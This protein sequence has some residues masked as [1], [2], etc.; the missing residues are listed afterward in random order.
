VGWLSLRLWLGICALGLASTLEVAAQ[1]LEAR[2]WTH[3]PVGTNIAGVGYG[4]TTGDLSFDPV[5]RID[6]AQVELHTILASYNR[7]FS[8]GDMTARVDVQVPYQLGTWD[9]LVNGVPMTVHRNGFGDPRIRLS[10]DFLGAPALEAKEFMDYIQAEPDRTIAGVGLATRVPL[11]QNDSDHL[12]NLGEHR[13]S[14]QPQLGVVQYLGPWSFEAT[15]SLFAYTDND[16]FFGG[17]RL[18]Q[19]P[20]YA[21]QLHVVRT[22]EAGWWVSAGSAYGR[23][24]RTSINGGADSD[25]RSNLLYGISGG[26]SPAPGQ[27][28]SL[29]YIRHVALSKVGGDYHNILV[30][31]AIRF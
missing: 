14:F 16:D 20:I 7:Y 26:M 9:G 17:N 12:I 24:G 28:I 22:F 5:L 13:F 27:S 1:D 6:N 10:L 18:D 23:G 30:G 29:T 11:G 31:W 2:R 8:V 19:D 15:A 3:L 25:V 4:Y 21:I